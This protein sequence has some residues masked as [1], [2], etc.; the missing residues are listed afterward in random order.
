MFQTL[1][2]TRVIIYI[3]KTHESMGLE[4]RIVVICGGGGGSG[5]TRALVGPLVCWS[6][7]DS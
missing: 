5:W 3:K 2:S 6:Y 7:S 1:K 4:V